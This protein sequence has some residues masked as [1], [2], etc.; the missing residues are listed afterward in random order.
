MFYNKKIR[1]IL[2]KCLKII[3]VRLGYA[4]LREG[5]IIV[6]YLTF[7]KPK[8]K[9]TMNDMGAFGV[10]LANNISH[11]TWPFQCQL[12]VSNQIKLTE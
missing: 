2:L 3:T 7:K 1:L 12:S 10:Y 5:S 11:H 8:F 9:K 4:S 6:M